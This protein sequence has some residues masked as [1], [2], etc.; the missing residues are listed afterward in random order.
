M[1]ETITLPNL[2]AG[3]P[4]APSI[5]PYHEEVI[6]E[7]KAWTEG[8][9]PLSPKSQARFDH[10]NFPLMAALAYPE[11]SRE[12]LRLTADFM[13]WFFYYDEI[14]DVKTGSETRK[15]AERLIAVM[16]YPTTVLLEDDPILVQKTR[17]LWLRT[18]AFSVSSSADRLL[19]GLEQ[20][21]LAVCEEAE[22]REIKRVR[23]IQEHLALRRGTVAADAVFFLGLLHID[24]PETV[25]SHPMVQRLTLLGNHLTC[26]HNDIY[27]YNFERAHGVH[28][29]NL[30]TAVM[31]EKG[32]GIQGAINYSGTLFQQ[33]VLEFMENASQ[34][35]ILFAGEEG[36]NIHIGCMLNVV[37]ALD[38]WSFL[39]P[40]YFEEKRFQVRRTL[41]VQLAPEPQG[42]EYDSLFAMKGE[43]KLHQMTMVD[44]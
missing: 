44:Q 28:G 13:M 18:L 15:L 11:V 27:S 36:L 35:S 43:M 3:W 37:V 31:K 33:A 41:T 19:S 26:F 25:M 17:D 29:H 24:I 20:F 14:T 30:V 9:Q 23:N 16:R 1:S 22:D 7:T 21:V 4:C 2:L 12:H 10:C 38:E 39:T 32:L 42:R 6:R 5:S 34:V 8:Y 40:R